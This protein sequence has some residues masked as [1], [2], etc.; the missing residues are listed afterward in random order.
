M[1]TDLVSVRE[2]APAFIIG[3]GATPSRCLS[4]D[5]HL[6]AFF[7]GCVRVAFRVFFGHVASRFGRAVFG[8]FLLMVLFSFVLVVVAFYYH[9][10]T[11]H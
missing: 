9:K 4:S 8:C 5:R 1:R 7:N 10:A 2:V 3:S 6:F 11:L